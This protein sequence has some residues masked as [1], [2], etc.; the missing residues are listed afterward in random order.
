MVNQT[1][2]SEFWRNWVECKKLLPAKCHLAKQLT[3]TG[4]ET[5]RAPPPL[6]T[7]S[8]PLTSAAPSNHMQENSPL[9]FLIDYP[10]P[11]PH[12]SRSLKINLPPYLLSALFNRW[13][14]VLYLPRSPAPGSLSSPEVREPSSQWG[15]PP[16]APLAA[17]ACISNKPLNC[18][19]SL[20]QVWCIS[21]SNAFKWEWTADLVPFTGI[22]LWANSAA[23]WLHYYLWTAP[24]APPTDSIPRPLLGLFP[25]RHTCSA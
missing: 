15:P 12:Q 18:L 3:P 7:H 16:G 25:T 19:W 10:Q 8:A 11:D 4:A 23:I 21:A 5:I 14:P 9:L 20:G 24:P 2:G 13:A 1:L 17:Y 6:T 22:L